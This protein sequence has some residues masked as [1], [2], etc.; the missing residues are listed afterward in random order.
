MHPV[1]IFVDEIDQ[2]FTRSRGSGGD[3]GVEQRLFARLLEFMEDRN[4]LG[5]VL[6]MAASNKPGTLDAALLSRFR[7]RLPFLLPDSEAILAMLRTQIPGQAG[8]EWDPATWQ[9]HEASVVSLAHQKLIG[10]FSGREIDS[11]VRNAY[12]T[13]RE[14]D[15]VSEA[16][17]DVSVLLPAIEAANISQ[18]YQQYIRW[19][20]DALSQIDSTA[21][22]MLSSIKEVLPE[23]IHREIIAVDAHGNEYLS[24]Q[25]LSTVTD[26][27][28]RYL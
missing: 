17:V 4:N 12:I 20:L 18:N 14:T 28:S 8:F 15:R 23:Q 5:K 3:G 22:R 6:W 25:H 19:S 11:L 13:A 16:G 10:K 27:L 2:T 1:I 24:L 26:D 9:T 7:M 21:P